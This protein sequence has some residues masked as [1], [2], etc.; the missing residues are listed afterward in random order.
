MGV[1]KK[2]ENI[3]TRRKEK[4]MYSSSDVHITKSHVILTPEIC[5]S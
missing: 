4:K 2:K 3:G 5:E 1:G